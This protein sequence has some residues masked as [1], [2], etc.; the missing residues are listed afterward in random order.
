MPIVFEASRRALARALF[1]AG[2]GNTKTRKAS[3]RITL[4]ESVLTITSIGGSHGFQV[5]SLET[6]DSGFV[7]LN[8]AKLA[9]NLPDDDPLPI[10][11]DARTLQIASHRVRF[12]PSPESEPSNDD[13]G[14]VAAAA[15]ILASHRVDECDVALLAIEARHRPSRFT[16]QEQPLIDVIANAWS[17]LAPLGITP[18]DLKLLMN[19]KLRTSWTDSAKT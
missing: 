18:D 16:F 15:K 5:E 3:T 19:E 13:A 9:L 12:R 14:R 4:A 11:L 7:T 2:A 8:A 6:F 10:R 1:I 17:L